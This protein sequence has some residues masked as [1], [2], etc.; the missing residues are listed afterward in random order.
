MIL[1]IQIDYF[2]SP[3]NFID[4]YLTR[5]IIKIIVSEFQRYI[6]VIFQLKRLENNAGNNQ[7]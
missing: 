3:I 4:I 2:Q 7:S 5:K 1:I 6:D